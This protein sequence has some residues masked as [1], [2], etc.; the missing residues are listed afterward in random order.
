MTLAHILG[1]GAIAVVL[2][3]LRS[4]RSLALLAINAWIV[5]W[6]QP[7]TPFVVLRFWLPFAT[8]GMTVLTWALTAAPEAR[9][10]RRNR[11]AGLVLIGVPLLVDWNRYFR[12]EAFFSTGTPP[13]GLFVAAL[14]GVVGGAW[15]LIRWPNRL[16]PA[17]ALLLIVL[18]FLLLKT[19]ALLEAALHDAAV[20][21]GTTAKSGSLS[22]LG[23]SYV[24]FRLMHTIRDR[25]SGRLPPLTLDEYVNYVIF[26]PSL[27]AG[28]ID[29]AERFLSELRNPLP[30]QS[31]DWLEAGG[32]FLTG[33]FKKFVLADLLAVLSLNETLVRHVQGAGWLWLFLY[34]YTLRLYFDFSGYTD[35]AIGLGRLMGIRLPENF[36]SPYLKANLTQ[37]WNAW[38]MTLTQW[39][40]AYYFNPLTRALRSRQPAVPAGLIILITQVS[41]MVLIGL[42]HGV[43]WGYALWGLWHGVGLFVQNRWSELARRWLSPVLQGQAIRAGVHLLGVFITFHFVA[44][45][46]LFFDLASPA[47]AW[48][49]LLKLFGLL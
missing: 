4:G 35:M 31:P 22:W 5:F 26:F 13:P 33:L 32:R 18:V 38:H 39:F 40:R 48:Q 1:L 14:L 42:W 9:E 25:Q 29:R 49:A 28:P 37:F 17:I 44:L 8:L 11:A 7:E 43:A 24:A 15:L 46:W 27:T 30:L 23:F 20:L 10:W 6:L 16:W 45:G 19:P 34:A 41:T 12:L 47:L 3:R 36:A 2:G 21:R